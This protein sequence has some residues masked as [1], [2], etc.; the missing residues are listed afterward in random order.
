MLRS[1]EPIL[2]VLYPHPPIFSI[3]FKSCFFQDFSTRNICRLDCSR[4][5]F[6]CL[7]RMC[8]ENLRIFDDSLGICFVEGFLHT[9]KIP[10]KLGKSFHS[11][12]SVSLTPKL[13]F[14][15]VTD[16]WP[17]ISHYV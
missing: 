17:K 13:F 4:Q 15:H 16:T 3:F 10:P 1:E 14:E 11:F 12:G 2:N 6:K 9:R 8:R 5:Y 7:V